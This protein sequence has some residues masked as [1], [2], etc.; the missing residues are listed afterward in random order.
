[1]SQIEFHP[2]RAALTAQVAGRPPAPP[3]ETS[4]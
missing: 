3:E 2:H 1:M 4:P